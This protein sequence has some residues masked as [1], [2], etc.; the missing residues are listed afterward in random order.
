MECSKGFCFVYG[1]VCVCVKDLNLKL[2]GFDGGELSC[3]S[4][5]TTGG[6]L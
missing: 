5:W 1:G 6:R 2:S 4:I 3:E